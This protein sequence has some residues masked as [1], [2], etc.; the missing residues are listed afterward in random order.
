MKWEEIY[1]VN[2]LRCFVGMKNSIKISIIQSETFMAHFLS[3]IYKKIV[4]N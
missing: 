3:M 4:I 2:A 1:I